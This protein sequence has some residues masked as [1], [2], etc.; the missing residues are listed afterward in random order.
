MVRHMN[1]Q[2]LVPLLNGKGLVL[3]EAEAT[4]LALR[5]EGIQIDMGNDAEGAGRRV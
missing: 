2:L 1:S 3:R 5:I 4:H